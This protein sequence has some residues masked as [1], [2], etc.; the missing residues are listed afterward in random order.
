MKRHLLAVA[1]IVSLATAVVVMGVAA[2]PAAA[3]D[4][5][6]T[7]DTTLTADHQGSIIIGADGITLDCAGYRITGPGF[8]GVDVRN[9]TGVTVKNCNVS[10]FALG[11]FLFSAPG[12]RLENNISS[13]NSHDGIVLASSPGNDHN[14]LVGNTSTG[15]GG[16][17]FAVYDGTTDTTLRGNTARSNS[18][19]G[20]FVGLGSNRTTLSENVAEQNSGGF[21]IDSDANTVTSNTATEN[22]GLGF[23]VFQANHNLLSGNVANR[24]AGGFLAVGPELD[25]TFIDNRAVDNENSGFAFANGASSN[26]LSGNAASG[27]RS[28][29]FAFISVSAIDSS[30]DQATGNG[31]NGFWLD[32]SAS[33]SFSHDLSLNNEHGFVVRASTGNLF[34]QD[35]ANHNQGF[36]FDL[37]DGSSGNTVTK[38]VAHANPFADAA[39]FDPA[40]ANT[41]L[42]NSFGTTFLP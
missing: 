8:A 37:Y 12:N 28:H 34:S 40:G 7:T 17:G 2:Q 20:F 33:S 10:G 31:D 32:S 42:D 21:D 14:T 19:A 30:D 24:N 16:W 26:R 11:F 18:F 36:G 15:N 29:G 38:C 1:A 35:V 9:V 41:W 3:A 13:G 23:F 39:D 27:N 6:I 4:L 22:A 5:I 25:N